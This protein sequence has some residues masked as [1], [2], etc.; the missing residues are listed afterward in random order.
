[1]CRYRASL[2]LLIAA[3]VVLVA[4]AAC[5]SGA[6]GQGVAPTS[7]PAAAIIVWGRVATQCT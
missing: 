7:T 3:V 2:N 4:T 6:A 1:M 5:G